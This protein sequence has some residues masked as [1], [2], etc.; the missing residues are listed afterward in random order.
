MI[1]FC[2]NE[3]GIPLVEYVPDLK[4]Q[5]A[6]PEPPNGGIFNEHHP[7]KAVSGW[8]PQ[9][10][11]RCS[12]MTLEQLETYMLYV[13]KLMSSWREEAKTLGH[14]DAYLLFD[15]QEFYAVYLRMAT[16]S[17]YISIKKQAEVE[18]ELEAKRYEQY[19][20]KVAAAAHNFKLLTG[21]KDND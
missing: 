1:K 5:L 21:D 6:I 17:E 7:Y 16:V 19:Q 11:H 8:G 13:N 4:D 9:A 18:L 15:G 12:G 14:A 3:D 10:L 20:E 2:F